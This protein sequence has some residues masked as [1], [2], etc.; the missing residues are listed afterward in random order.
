MP[1]AP[2]KALLVDS[3]YDAYL[4][5]I[6][7][8]RIVDGTLKA[9]MK[10]RMMGSGASHLIDRVGVFTPKMTDAAALGPGEIGFL[11]ASIKSVADCEVGDTITEERR[12][13][14]EA[15][16]G[17]APSVPVVFCGLFPVDAN[18]YEDLRDSLAKLALNDSSFLFEAETSAAL[19]FGFRCGFLGLA[20]SGDRAGAAD[21]RVRSR[22]HHHRAQRGL[23]HHAQQRRHPGAAQSHRHARSG[24]DRHPSP[25]PGSRP[26]SWC[27]TSSS[28]RC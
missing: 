4:G 8:V 9:G 1:D 17:F 3:W 25:S 15:L 16:A 18:D 14:A 10:V 21:P 20:A 6:V 26:P 27:P 24:P 11:T 23:P 13:A 22:P 5:V 12:P 19:G 2:L 7:L 28:A